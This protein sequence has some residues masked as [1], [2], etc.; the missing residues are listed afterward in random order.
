[1]KTFREIEKYYSHDSR[2]FIVVTI[3]FY[4][5]KCNVRIYPLHSRNITL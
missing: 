1:M 4:N 3:E 2:A 5:N